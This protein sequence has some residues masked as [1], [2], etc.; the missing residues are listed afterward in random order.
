MTRVCESLETKERLS[1]PNFNVDVNNG[2]NVR[3][4]DR[5][6]LKLRLLAQ[7]RYSYATY[8]S[9]WGTV[10]D[11]RNPEILGGQVEYRA[12]R[13]RNPIPANSRF[14]APVFNSWDTPGTPIFA[15]TSPC[16]SIRRHRIKKEATAEPDSWTPTSRPGIS[17]GPTSKSGNNG[18]G[19]IARPI[20]PIATST[21]ADNMIV[22]NA[23]A[24]NLSTTA[25][26]RH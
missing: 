14:L 25:R 16:S 18:C 12:V 24:A 11:S 9:A 8:N 7:A 21:F 13:Y 17:P 1:Q 19:S 2:F 4:G 10:G 23:F 5:F 22:Q 3:V 6:L 20:S 26:H 15:T